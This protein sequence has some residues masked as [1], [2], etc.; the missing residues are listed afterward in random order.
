MSVLIQEKMNQNSL[1]QDFR[2]IV[3]DL[4]TYFHYQKEIGIEG[5][6][7]VPLNI[8]SAEGDDTFSPTHSIERA[9]CKHNIHAL[10]TINDEL[11]DCKRCKLHSGRRNIVFGTG[12]ES[13]KLVFVG[14]A[15][16][17]DEDIQG[18]PFVGK[19]GQLLTRIIN[20][21]RLSRND[22]YIANIIKCRP[23]G[24]RDPEQ[25]EIAACEPFLIK[26]IQ[27]I[28][29]DIICALGAFAAQTL[30]RTTQK[31]SDLRGRF[32]DY[33][34]TKLIPTYHPAYLLRNPYFKRHVWE[35]MQM[36]QKEYHY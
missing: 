3:L 34:G 27:V 8:D 36:I 2:E 17:R 18:E 26:Q 5:F 19:A 15:P 23:P 22:V 31:I 12:N 21:I 32:H 13:A 4:K 33:Q 30:L 1:L 10:E 16:G 6:L 24:N 14:E 20:A 28:N 9:I 25:D 7:R 11:Q 29:P 35:D